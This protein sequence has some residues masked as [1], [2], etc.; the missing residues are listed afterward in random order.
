M[1]IEN[2]IQEIVEKDLMRGNDLRA[3]TTTHLGQRPAEARMRLEAPRGSAPSLSQ[4]GF[5]YVEALMAVVILSMAMLGI[6]PLFVTAV[7]KNAAARDM[8]LA[9]VIAQDKVEDLKTANIIATGTDSIVERNV[10][11]DRVWSVSA[12]TPHPGLS[13]VTVTVTPQRSDF[14]GRPRSFSM[15]FYRA[16]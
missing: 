13:T 14:F 15:S 16:Y 1:Q 2:D 10:T 8:T 4:A 5:L 12:N 3:K 11:F 9:S 7:T 6:V